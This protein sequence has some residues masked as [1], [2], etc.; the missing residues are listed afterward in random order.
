M[1][2]GRIAQRRL[3]EDRSNGVSFIQRGFNSSVD[4]IVVVDDSG[5]FIDAN[6]AALC[7]YGVQ[8]QELIGRSALNFA[9]SGFDLEQARQNFAG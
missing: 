6:P 4:G 8:A 1:L 5:I 3:A 9:E 2:L 7:L